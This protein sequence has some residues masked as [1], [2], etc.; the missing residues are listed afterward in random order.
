M[1]VEVFLTGASVGPEDVRGTTAVVID[2][3]RTSTTVAAALANGARA[4]VPVAD[5]AEAA[6]VAAN[7]DP[8]T[9]LLGGER[10]GVTIDGY[11][12]GNSPREYDAATVRDRTVVMV[13]TNGTGAVVRCA[14]AAEVVIGGL[15][16]ARAVV[17]HVLD[18]GRDVTIVC[19]GW[20]NR[21][22]LE[23]T[24]CAGLLID[25]MFPGR[26]PEPETDTAHIALAQYRYDRDGLVERIGTCNHARRLVALGHAA[27]IPLCSAV[28][29]IPVVPAYRDGRLVLAAVAAGA[30]FPAP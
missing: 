4:V 5:M 22:S 16:N 9:M 10:G 26:I 29:S 23:D 11:H 8:S 28:D 14:A 6:R 19:A 20:K 18:R 25:L 7:L 2:V 3:L 15:V 13:T 12:L 30:P 24:L 27:D 17:D 1:N 21:V